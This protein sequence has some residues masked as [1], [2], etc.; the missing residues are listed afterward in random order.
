[1]KSFKILLLTALL[2]ASLC[3]CQSGGSKTGSSEKATAPSEIITTAPPT[4]PPTGSMV[5]AGREKEFVYN[6][7]DNNGETITYKLPMLNFQTEDAKKINEEI[8]ELYDECFTTAE[9]EYADNKSLS[10]ESLGYESYLNDDIITLL[11]SKEEDHALTYSVFNYNKTTGKRL[12]NAGLLEYLKLDAEQTYSALKTQLE[13]DYYSKFK[14]ENFPDDY[15]YQL[16]MTVGDEA[17]TQSKLF[18]NREAELFA[19]CT[20][21]ASVGKGEFQVMIAIP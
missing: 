12:D 1:M 7:G 16:E 6:D 3:A 14:Y 13:D 17:L 8:G 4:D 9:Q 21:Y 19:I 2:C 11:I 18:L 15:Y 5:V 10:C 20:E